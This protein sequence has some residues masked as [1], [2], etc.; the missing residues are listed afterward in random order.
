MEID[1]QNFILCTKFDEFMCA[2]N[3]EEDLKVPLLPEKVTVWSGLHCED[4]ISPHFLKSEDR[5]GGTING[6]RH[7]CRCV[8]V[9]TS[10]FHF[11]STKWF[12]Q[13]VAQAI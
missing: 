3:T 6:E 9:P 8:L 4:A 5:A 7:R 13:N 12:H 11:L 10:I 2:N 1:F